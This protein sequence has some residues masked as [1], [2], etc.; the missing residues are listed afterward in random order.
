MVG[1]DVEV[2]VVGGV[3]GL[4]CVFSASAPLGCAASGSVA[5]S[6][7]RE[8]AGVGSE[9]NSWGKVGLGPGLRAGSGG[10]DVY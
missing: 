1:G 6:D 2:S 8:G 9:I 4:A 7:T 10:L 3:E 5:A